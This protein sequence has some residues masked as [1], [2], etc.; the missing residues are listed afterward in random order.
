[1]SIPIEKEHVTIDLNSE[2]YIHR[3][4]TS[5][6]FMLATQKLN[7][8]NYG[9]WKRA[10]EIF[11]SAKNKL[12]FVNGTCVKPNSNSSQLGYW[13]R[14]N[15]LVLSCILHSVEL[16]IRRSILYFQT[17]TE[18]WYDLQERYV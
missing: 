5:S 10:A 17:A 7:G 3:G 2:L 14:C 6:N 4:D 13:E 12:G 18:V 1:M 8:D 9:E 11:L 15:N 16:E